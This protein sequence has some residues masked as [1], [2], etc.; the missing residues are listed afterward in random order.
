MCCT[1][2]AS[3]G[4]L[5]TERIFKHDPPYELVERL[6]RAIEGDCFALPS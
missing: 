6:S 1:A 4:G 3:N 5:T 2:L